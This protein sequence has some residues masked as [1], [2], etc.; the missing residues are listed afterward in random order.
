MAQRRVYGSPPLVEALCEIR[1]APG[2]E[3]DWTVPGLFYAQVQEVYP[4]KEQTEQV[5][6]QWRDDPAQMQRQTS[7]RLRFFNEDKTAL[8]Q[9]G[10]DLLVFN[11]L[12]P[13]PG[14]S[15][16]RSML[17]GVL[18]KYRA[19]ATPAGV[20]ACA[21][22][23]LNRLSIPQDTATL[24][25]YLLAVPT[26]PKNLPDTLIGWSL[27]LDIPHQ[28][29]KGIMHLEAGSVP[30]RNS[31]EVCFVLDLRFQ[32]INPEELGLNGA[33]L[34]WID[35]AH[36][37]IEETFEASITDQARSIFDEELIHGQLTAR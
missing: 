11:C 17:V 14:W 21:V 29:R 28:A 4:R 34:D 19:V 36:D 12:S 37:I 22:R 13:Y 10:K 31:N 26:I 27:S 9:V 24:E 15:V 18:E 2:Q 16:F 23:Y 8:V 35:N 3:W 6:V 32:A 33:L 20:A 5:E 30:P 1:F 7:R 25:D